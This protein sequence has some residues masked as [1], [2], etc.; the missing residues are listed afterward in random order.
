MWGVCDLG[1]FTLL[2]SLSLDEASAVKKIEHFKAIVARKKNQIFMQGK[3][4][5]DEDVI[6]LVTKFVRGVEKLRLKARLR[7]SEAL[8]SRIVERPTRIRL[9]FSS[10]KNLFRLIW[11]YT[12][13]G[14]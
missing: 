2:V 11:K 8:V 5:K 9:A 12:W 14:G 4:K 6:T 1:I 13:K 7:G 10:G 3:A